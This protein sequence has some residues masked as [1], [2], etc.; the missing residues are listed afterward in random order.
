IWKQLIT[1][2]CKTPLHGE[3]SA[4]DIAHLAHAL[5]ES[6]KWTAVQRNRAR[7]TGDKPNAPDLAQLLRP[8]HD[9]PRRRAAEQ[10]DKLAAFHSITSS[11]SASSR[12]GI[13]SQRA[14]GVLKLII[15]SIFVGCNTGRSGGFSLLRMRRI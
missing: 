15:N 8:S 11:A 14:V 9:R 3:V 10:R 12:S 5:E 6:G 13:W 1:R 2:F 7:A 4:F